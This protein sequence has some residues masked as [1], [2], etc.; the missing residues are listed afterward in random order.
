VLTNVVASLILVPVAIFIFRDKISWV[1]I[2]SKIFIG[3]SFSILLIFWF[4]VLTDYSWNLSW[5][6]LIFPILVGFVSFFLAITVKRFARFPRW[7]ISLISVLSILM[8]G[9]CVLF[10]L[11]DI[12]FPT[13]STH[14][15]RLLL[16]TEDSPNKTRFVE[17]Y[18]FTQSAHGGTDRISIRV[19]YKLLPF[20]KRDLAF[21]YDYPSQACQYSG[22]Q[23]VVWKDDNTTLVIDRQ[24]ELAVGLVD[25]V[26][27]LHNDGATNGV[28]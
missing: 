11:P 13:I 17:A 18:C 25:W 9:L 8:S 5:L 16:Q 22:D 23:I 4:G 10:F 14:R 24:I 27:L 2:T 26:G 15:D 6:N 12:A 1:N 21:Y 28:Y 3:F 19:R 20:I 7:L